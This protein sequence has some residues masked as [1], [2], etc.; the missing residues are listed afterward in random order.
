MVFELAFANLQTEQKHQPGKQGMVCSQQNTTSLM[1]LVT[2]L[3]FISWQFQGI[4]VFFFF[5][6][7]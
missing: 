3:K 4:F 1:F 6:I 2:F 7:L 5:C